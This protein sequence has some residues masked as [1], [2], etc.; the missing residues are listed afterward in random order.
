LQKY[1]DENNITY[2][3]DPFCGGANIVD[4]IKCEHRIA[5]DYN[6]DLIALLKYAQSDNNLS[7]APDT[8]SFEH[9][10]DVRSN[11]NTGK[12]SQEYI[13]LIGYCA[14]YGGR[15]WD[16]GY[17][18]DSKGGRSIYTERV[19]NL[20]QQ[21]PNLIGIDFYCRDYKE[22]L[23]MDIHNALFYLDPPYNGTKQY[24]KQKIN[25]EEYYDFCK[26]L[27]ENN[28]VVISE[29]NMPDDFTC[30]WKKERKVLQKSDRVTGDKAVEKLFVYDT[31]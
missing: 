18:R 22:Y 16:G 13:A 23:D 8:C 19:S 9:Y 7:I 12:Y 25:Y 31:H 21:A 10:A 27:S 15:Y 6:E 2:F 26:K 14:S 1:I 24:S 4:K 29:Y 5:S 28:I 17:G 30:I 3:Y 20:K 11:R